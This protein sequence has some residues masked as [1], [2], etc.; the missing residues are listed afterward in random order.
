M[1][2]PKVLIV[3]QTILNNGHIL[4]IN[5]EIIK[6]P[7][8]IYCSRLSTCRPKCPLLFI[9]VE[10]SKSIN[11]A[12]IQ[13]ICKW[14]SL[15]RSKACNLFLPFSVKDIDIKMCHVQIS[16]EY[17]WLPFILLEFLEVRLEVNIPFFDSVRE[18]LQAVTRVG[19]VGWHKDEVFKLSGGH[20]PLSIMLTYSE[21]ICDGDRFNLGQYRSAGIT[22]LHLA[23]VPILLI[24]WRHL[25]VVTHLI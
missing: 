17:E 23:A 3:N 10:M 21:V 11:K 5:H 4:F 7:P 25:L 9:R 19:D 14:L 6:P 24:V 13:K 2:T 16:T 22:F 15:L 1:I 20:S 12:L 18:P 8:I